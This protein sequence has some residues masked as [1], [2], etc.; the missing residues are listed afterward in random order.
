MEHLEIISVAGCT[1]ATACNYNVDATTD[2]GSCLQDLGCGCGE[3]AAADGFDCAGNCLSGTTITMEVDH[4]FQKH[5]G[6]LLIVMV[7]H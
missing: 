4:T 3:P 7:I 1:D 5:L 2:D 6:Q